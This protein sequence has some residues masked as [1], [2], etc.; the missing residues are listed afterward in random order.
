M[1]L[2]DGH[3]NICDKVVKNLDDLDKEVSSGKSVVF[4]MADW[5]DPCKNVVHEYGGDDVK[6]ALGDRGVKSCYVDVD[7]FEGDV[8]RRS[9]YGTSSV[10]SM[11]AFEDGELIGASVG[12][13]STS[14]FMDKVD[15]WYRPR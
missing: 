1:G 9:K 12:Q 4:F 14:S 10:P 8:G 13:E 2:I 3:E 11:L 7:E 15:G 5:C 6:S